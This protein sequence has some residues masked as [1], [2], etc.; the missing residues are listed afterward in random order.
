MNDF[1]EPNSLKSAGSPQC[2]ALVLNYFHKG[3]TNP[4][5]K[6]RTA[7]MGLPKYL[8]AD[9]TAPTLGDDESRWVIAFCSS[10]FHFSR[11][12]LE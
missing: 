2:M 7:A 11:C 8:R 6:V 10:L 3:G 9:N 1:T 5:K 4:A 12:E